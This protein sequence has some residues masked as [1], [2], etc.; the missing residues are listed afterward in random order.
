MAPSSSLRRVG[1]FSQEALLKMPAMNVDETSLRVDKKNHWVHVYSAGDI[2]LKCLNRGRGIKAIDTIDIVPRYGGVIIHDCWASYFSY[3]HCG[4]GLCGSHLMRE[5]TFVVE[6][7]G[8]VWA[9]NMKRLLKETC[10]KVSKNEQKKLTDK[11]YANLQKRFR[12]IITRGEKRITACA[13]Q[14]QR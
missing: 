4:H 7:N 14:T 9:K 11:D 5:L 2:T 1:G 13:T 8:Y 12:N 10:A 3:R 6:S